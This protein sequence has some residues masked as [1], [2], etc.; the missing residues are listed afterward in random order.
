[1]TD[2]NKYESTTITDTVPSAENVVNDIAFTMDMENMP[3]SEQ[4]KQRLLD[5]INGK[6]NVHDV[7]RETIMKYSMYEVPA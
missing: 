1:M 6:V 2:T 3:L 5:C 4:E 7:L